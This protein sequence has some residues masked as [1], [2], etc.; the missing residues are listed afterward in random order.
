MLVVGLWAPRPKPGI[1]RGPLT[2]N[3]LTVLQLWDVFRSLGLSQFTIHGVSYPLRNA[4]G[5]W[6]VTKVIGFGVWYGQAMYSYQHPPR[7]IGTSRRLFS[8]RRISL[9]V[10]IV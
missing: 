4:K 10:P 8:W 6:C 3:F 1:F 5:C 9:L 7:I 2:S